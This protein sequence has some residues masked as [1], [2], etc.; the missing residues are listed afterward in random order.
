MMRTPRAIAPEETIT[1]SL[2]SPMQRGD[3]VADAREHAVRSSPSSS[4][5]MLEPSFMTTRFIEGSLD[6]AGASRV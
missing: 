1:T 2:P 6:G 4:A 3:L 5:T